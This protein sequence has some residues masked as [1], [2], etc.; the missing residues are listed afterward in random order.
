MDASDASTSGGLSDGSSQDAAPDG[1]DTCDSPVVGAFNCCNGKPCR[2]WCDPD[3]NCDCGT[4]LGG[5]IAPTVCCTHGICVSEVDC[6]GDGMLYSGPEYD[7]GTD[8]APTSDNGYEHLSC[9]EGV[10]C[11]G[12]CELHDGAWQCSCSGIL[13]GCGPFDLSCCEGGC[14]MESNCGL[15]S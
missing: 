9:C 5:C 15:P 8:C 2:G 1:P 6:N 13:G 3:G 14:T 4:G 11:W 7:G 12:D 10:P